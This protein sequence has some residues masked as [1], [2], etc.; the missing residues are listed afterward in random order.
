MDQL[1]LAEEGVSGKI[2]SW[3]GSL[4]IMDDNDE[5][6]KEFG[7]STPSIIPYRPMID[8]VST[9]RKDLCGYSGKC[10]FDVFAIICRLDY[11]G[12]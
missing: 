6:M 9:F 2:V 12:S 8:V 5:L 3:F 11:I 10:I 7:T 1:L 4:K